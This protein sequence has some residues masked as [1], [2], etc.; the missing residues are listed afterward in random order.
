MQLLELPLQ[1]LQA[2]VGGP[3]Q[4]LHVAQVAA[5]CGRPPQ[6]L[7]TL[8]DFELLLDGPA[9][10]LFL[11]AGWLLA[12]AR[13]WVGKGAG[14]SVPAA[15]S[16]RAPGRG[17]GRRGWHPGP[18]QGAPEARLTA[19]GVSP[20]RVETPRLFLRPRLLS[21]AP[22]RVRGKRFLV[23]AWCGGRPGSCQGF[24]YETP[25]TPTATPRGGCS[26][27]PPRSPGEKTE[28]Q[29]E[30]RRPARWPP[31]LGPCQPRFGGR[32]SQAGAQA[33]TWARKQ[34]KDSLQVRGQLEARGGAGA[35]PGRDAEGPGKSRGAAPS[36]APG[37]KQ[38][39]SHRFAPG[40]SKEG[41]LPPGPL[42]TSGANADLSRGPAPPRGSSRPLPPGCPSPGLGDPPAGPQAARA[43][44]GAQEILCRLRR[45]RAKGRANKGPVE[46]GARP[47]G[48]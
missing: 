16:L 43:Q 1:L 17:R 39:L 48:S 33:P 27:Q 36:S 22:R 35:E 9:D 40:R 37:R 46:L 10:Q 24:A 38:P 32:R 30:V 12:L 47:P 6:V 11:V 45:G 44:G 29:R 5:V 8:L 14:R 41:N 13:L 28:A 3:E 7:H 42:R 25:S 19:E 23:R 2:A 15:T 4:L 31:P 20:G 34:A 18:A 26:Y 21:S